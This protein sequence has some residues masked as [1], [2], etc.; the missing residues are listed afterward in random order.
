M[1]ILM[2]QLL[3]VLKALSNQLK[4]DLWSK[5]ILKGSSSLKLFKLNTKNISWV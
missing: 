2:S 4:Y 1:N 3:V 5:L